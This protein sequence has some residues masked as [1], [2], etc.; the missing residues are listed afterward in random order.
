VCLFARA[1]ADGHGVFCT[2]QFNWWFKH[3]KGAEAKIMGLVWPYGST[4]G[5]LSFCQMQFN[6]NQLYYQ[7]KEKGGLGF[8]NGGGFD[9]TCTSPDSGV[10]VPAGGCAFSYPV[11]ANSTCR[12]KIFGAS[13]TPE[14]QWCQYNLE[15][16]MRVGPGSDGTINPDN[17]F[18]CNQHTDFE[19]VGATA[20]NSPYMAK[21]ILFD[22]FANTLLNICP[23]GA[24]DPSSMAQAPAALADNDHDE[25]MLALLATGTGAAILMLALTVAVLVGVCRL[26]RAR[27]SSP[28]SQ[29]GAMA[30][31]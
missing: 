5:P 14:L 10:G 19:V 12:L 25:L 16:T 9:K 26:S 22:V 7:F 1:A 31:V 13:E 11:I 6:A 3:D 23:S 24:G 27:P 30:K 18:A 21:G 2:T 4:Y 29:S 15:G 20:S 17:N 28:D 8:P